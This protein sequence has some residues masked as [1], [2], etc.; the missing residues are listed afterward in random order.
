MDNI[1]CSNRADANIYSETHISLFR[2]LIDTFEEVVEE[3]VE[4]GFALTLSSRIL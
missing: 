3:V 4:K 2:S 1:S